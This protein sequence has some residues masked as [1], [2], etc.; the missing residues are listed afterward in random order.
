MTL[1]DLLDRLD[2]EWEDDGFLGRLRQGDF[3]PG[4]SE[5]L[6]SLLRAIPEG[7]E[8]P[9]ISRRLV[10]LTWFIPQFMT[11]QRER[12]AE[13]GGDVAALDSGINKVQELMFGF[14]GVP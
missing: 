1:D 9:T 4:G 2:S 12:V 8:E 3:D 6:L 13:V 14:L 5:R 10:A 11:W 7:G